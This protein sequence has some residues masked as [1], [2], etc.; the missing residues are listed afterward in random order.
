MVGF[1]FISSGTFAT[2][3]R[4]AFLGSTELFQAAG[5]DNLNGRRAIR[6]NYLA[7]GAGRGV[8]LGDGDGYTRVP[9]SGAL[10]ID[11]ATYDVL[12]LRIQADALSSLPDISE[13]WGQLDYVASSIGNGAFLVP[14]SAHMLVR[15][16]N[17]VQKHNR[18]V[19]SACRL[20]GVSSELSFGDGPEAILA[21]DSR[22]ERLELPA[23]AVLRVK[24]G[25]RID[26]EQS[27][28]GDKIEG[29]LERAVKKGGQLVVPKGAIVIGR[30]R[31]LERF[32]KPTRHILGLEITEL[33]F[34]NRVARIQATLQ[35][36]SPIP[37]QTIGGA[38]NLNQAAGMITQ[39]PHGQNQTQIFTDP[40]LP[41]VGMIPIDAG[42]FKI[43]PGWKTAWKVEV[44]E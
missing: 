15:L 31:R 29:Q 12:R 40:I 14:R 11:A 18:S 30:I 19:F 42:K 28:V 41:G 26:S 21:T 37:G 3:L 17:E 5:E 32:R 2:A 35:Q 13:I 34:E 38:R 44:A 43:P 24:F 10:W 8:L 23:N 33:R 36:V 27:S 7:Q 1:G 20:F 39:F 6:Y 16:P 22:M 4:N 25:T 9:Y